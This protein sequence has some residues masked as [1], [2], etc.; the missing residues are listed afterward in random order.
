MR[1]IEDD[2]EERLVRD[3]IMEAEEVAASCNAGRDSIVVP[4]GL[5]LNF[6][7][8]PFPELGGGPVTFWG[9]SFVDDNPVLVPSS[10]NV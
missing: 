3:E 4:S 7:E 1:R 5:E 6:S 10:Q 2:A 9:G 8:D